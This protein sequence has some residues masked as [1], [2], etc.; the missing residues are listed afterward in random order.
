MV[1]VD[2][3]LIND[4]LIRNAFN[5]ENGFFDHDSRIILHIVCNDGI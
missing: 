1:V 3:R 2:I 5:R 4:F